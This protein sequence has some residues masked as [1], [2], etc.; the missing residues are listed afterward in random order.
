VFTSDDGSIAASSK[1]QN[2]VPKAKYEEAVAVN[3]HRKAHR[4]GDGSAVSAP[5]G[6]TASGPAGGL[7]SPAAT[8]PSNGATKPSS[9]D[10]AGL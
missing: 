9:G 2:F 4:Y 8:T 3:A 7:G 6:A 10:L 5:A 1:V